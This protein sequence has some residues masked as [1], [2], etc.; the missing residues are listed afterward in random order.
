MLVSPNTVFKKGLPKRFVRQQ[1]NAVRKCQISNYKRQHDAERLK[2]V[3]VGELPTKQRE[4]DMIT[5]SSEKM[6][7]VKRKILDKGVKKCQVMN[8][9]GSRTG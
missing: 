9:Y 4:R 7:T 8:Q 2:S 3:D 5:F 6:G 1:C